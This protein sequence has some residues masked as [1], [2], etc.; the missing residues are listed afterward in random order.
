MKGLGDW[1]S[2]MSIPRDYREAGV[3]IDKVSEIHKSIKSI[4]EKTFIFREGRVGSVLTGIGHYA[5]LI[6]LWDGKALAVHVDGV[7]SKV[8]IAQMMNKYDTIGIDCVAMCVN[9][10]ICM[11]AEPIA[12]ADYLVVQEPRSDLIEPIME[13]IAKGAE[14][15]SIAV[16]CGE[17]AVMKDVVKGVRDGYG[18]DLAAMCIGIVDKRRVLTGS[19][20][21]PGDYVVGLTSSG[22]HSNGLTLARKVLLSKFT[23]NSYVKELGCTLG[24]EL[25]KP[26]RIYVKPVL[27]ILSEFEVHGLAHITGGAFTKLMRIGRLAHLGFN[28]Y[29]MPEPPSVFKLIQSIG[30]IDDREMYR[31]F[32]MGI[33]FCIIVPP[34][35][36]DDV[37]EV[38]KKMGIEAQIIGEASEEMEIKI[39]V[40]D[41]LL[42]LL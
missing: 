34:H 4:L 40:N 35:E 6:D 28:L 22:I 9:D 25:L 38:C 13:G 39:K 16:I 33:G 5:G 32:N 37:V 23:I 11:G 3:D 17:T 8:L 36:A 27:R 21:K 42:T 31:T 10:L 15:A 29:N 19:S 18:F 30:S 1:G 20:I 24:E 14:E 41:R 7:G 12:L 26:T 2:K